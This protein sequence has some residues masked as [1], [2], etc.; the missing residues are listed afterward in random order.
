MDMSKDP[1]N[2]EQLLRGKP[3]RDGAEVPARTVGPA[4]TELD[5][6]VAE[7]QARRLV[8]LTIGPGQEVV[9]GQIHVELLPA[10]ES[11]GV[12]QRDGQPFERSGAELVAEELLACA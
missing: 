5:L 3:T 12:G 6:A 9:S 4:G 1:R 7:A 8:G 10:N 2:E 11:L